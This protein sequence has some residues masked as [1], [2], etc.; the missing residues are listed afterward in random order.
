MELLNQYGIFGLFV[1]AFLAATILPFSSEALLLLLVQQSGQWVV[2]VIAASVGNILGSVVNYWLGL[3][4]SRILLHKWL[5]IDNKTLDKAERNFNRFGV[6]SLLFAWLPVVGDPLTVVAGL[7][8]TRFSLFLLL[9]SLGKA[10][11]YLAL[12]WGLHLIT[13]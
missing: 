10:G 9:V 6:Y 12:V 1:A 11:R 4:G 13:L 2:P 5:R 8:K 7:F 3:K